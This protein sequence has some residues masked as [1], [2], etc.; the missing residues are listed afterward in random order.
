M[1][2]REITALLDDLTAG[3]LIDPS[4]LAL[5]SDLDRESASFVRSQWPGIP[6]AVREQLMVMAVELSEAHLDMDFTRF[7]RVA[8]DDTVSAIRR[9]GIAG[10]WETT[11]REIGERL[12]TLLNTD[13][14]DEVREAAAVA[15]QHFVLE[16][17][18]G[19]LRPGQIEPIL[20]ALRRAATDPAES[21]L[22]RARALAAVSV[23][24][25]PWVPALISEA[26]YDDSREIQLAAIEGMGLS[27]SDDWLDFVT[28]QLASE[29]PDFRYEAAVAAGGIMAQDVLEQLVPLFEDDEPEVARA[30]VLAVGEIGGPEAVRFLR[31]FAVEAPAE[32]QEALDAALEIASEARRVA[33]DEEFEDED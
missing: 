21:E 11:D 10:I 26:Y 13:E 17:E 29:D 4:R 30:A 7:A 2:S 27:A 12:T 32:M 15:L 20:A 19:R 23:S 5:F 3:I 31:N 28:E 8:L 24:T 16:S 1:P 18:Y 6:V 9:L 25:Q 14:S 33:E 22:V